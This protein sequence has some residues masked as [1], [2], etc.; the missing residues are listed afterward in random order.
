MS[1][2]VKYQYTCVPVLKFKWYQYHDSI[3]TKPPE[4]KYYK[5]D[6]SLG[7]SRICSPNI[8]LNCLSVLTR[9]LHWCRRFD[10]VIPEN[11]HNFPMEEIES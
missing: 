4:Y 10:W 8:I 11:I 7:N 1:Q 3:Y 2:N 5:L 9:V 6:T